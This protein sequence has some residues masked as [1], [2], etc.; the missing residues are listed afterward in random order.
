MVRQRQL[1]FLNVH[2]VANR[3]RTAPGARA[4]AAA[5]AS[6]AT[7]HPAARATEA[8]R[9]PEPTATDTAAAQRSVERATLAHPS[10]GATSFSTTTHYATSLARCATAPHDPGRNHAY[11]GHL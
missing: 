3:A 8:K 5:A 11:D 4:G 7:T 6:G 9:L 2:R 10:L 1:A